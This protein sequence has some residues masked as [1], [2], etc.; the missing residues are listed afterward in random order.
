MLVTKK[1]H[2]GKAF[3][4]YDK[5]MHLWGLSLPLGNKGIELYLVGLKLC[6]V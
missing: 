5:K 2:K 3:G 1:N 4:P 6:S